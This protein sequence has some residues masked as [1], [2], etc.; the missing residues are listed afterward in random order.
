[1]N[2]VKG[3]LRPVRDNILVT[4][5]EFGMERTKSGLYIQ[6][7]DGKSSGVHP[8][9]ARVYAIGKE[10]THVKVGDWILLEHGRWSRGFTYETENGDKITIHLADKDAILLVSDQKPDDIVRSV[11]IGAGSN[12]NFNIPNS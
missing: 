4:D 8:R 7:D 1:M 2:E 3:I 11:S 9:W 10:Q 5:M 6:S 12:V